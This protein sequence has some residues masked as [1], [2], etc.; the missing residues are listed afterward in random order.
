MRKSS[1]QCEPFYIL[2]RTEI[3]AKLKNCETT[4]I[5]EPYLRLPYVEEIC[6]KLT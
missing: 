3:E 5:K 1:P 2:T 6:S 4:L